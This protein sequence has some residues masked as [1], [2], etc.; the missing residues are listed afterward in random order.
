L[1]MPES[2]LENDAFNSILFLIEFFDLNL[3]KYAI[4]V[5]LRL[6]KYIKNSVIFK[7]FILPAIPNLTNLTKFS[8]NS[9]IE[10]YIL[11][12]AIGCFYNILKS[13]KAYNLD[14]NNKSIYKQINEFGLVSNLFEGV[15]NFVNLVK[16]SGN[17]KSTDKNAI[18]AKNSRS[19]NNS[20]KGNLNFSETIKRIFNIFEIFSLKSDEIANSLLDIE[21][22]FAS[23][24]IKMS[25]FEVINMMLEC[26]I[27]ANDKQQHRN[28]EGNIINNILDTKE[29]SSNDFNANV[30]SNA[31]FH[32]IFNNL[33]SFLTALFPQEPDFKANYKFN[34]VENNNNSNHNNNK[35]L[36]EFKTD[37]VIH[38]L[39][40]RHVDYFDWNSQ[41]GNISSSNNNNIEKD[42]ED[43]NK[44]NE[45][46]IEN[47]ENINEI[48]KIENEEVKLKNLKVLVNKIIPKTLKNF[49]N[50]SSSNSSFKLLKFIKV[51]IMNSDKE[52]I[53]KT[54]NPVLIS[55]VFSSNLY[56]IN[57]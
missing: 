32:Q 43:K 52:L 41:E 48:I 6:S 33:F 5:C 19:S 40:N 17:E 9:E 13:V 18:L 53:R 51:F 47:A 14:F 29:I 1:E 26:E 24:G 4:N 16:K 23:L 3:R 30:Y 7:Q 34:L 44:E 2:L 12:S 55:N 45:M 28:F 36:L 42:I 10:K 46:E 22:K 21:C 39:C 8:G 20:S 11:D 15:L 50:F 38:K 37:K 54:I 35:K 57:F 56:Y 49:I 25:V 27:G 31:N